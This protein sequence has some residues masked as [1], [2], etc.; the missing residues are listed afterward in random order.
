MDEARREFLK[1]AGVATVA[2]TTLAGCSGGGGGG[3]GDGG[4]GG[5]GQ[6]SWTLGTSSEGS[7]SFRIGS[8]WSQYAEQNDA[9][10]SVSV[11]AVITEGTGASYRRFDAGEFEM[12]GTT[13]QLLDAAPD[14]GPYEDQGLQDFSNHRQVRGYMGFYN[15]GLYNADAVSGWDDLEGRPIAISSAGS[16][17]RPPVEAIVDAEIGLDNVD[18]RYMAFAD[19]PSAL[20]SGQVDAAFTWTVNQTTPQGWFQEIDATVNWEPL[21]ISQSTRDLLNNELGYSTYVQLDAD[22]VSQFAENYQDPLDTF[23]LTYLYVVN[24]N[25]DADVVY[26]IARFTHQEGEA[27]LEQDDVMA[28]FPDPDRFLGQLHPDVPLH[29]G[30]YRYYEEEGLL[31]DYDLTAPPEA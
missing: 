15:F 12:S 31:E 28:F 30:A 24:A 8:T 25:A 18:N 1:R 5:G 2:T 26:D 21:P 20:R 6:A 22:T 9:L 23:T 3:G 16:G 17:T 13:T 10:D 11:D 27:L 4:D 7:S 19:I 14:T 29:E